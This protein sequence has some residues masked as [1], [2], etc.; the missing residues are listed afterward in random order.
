MNK[1]LLASAIASAL[2]VGVGAQAA[3][4]KTSG[5]VSRAIVAP[6][7]AE[8]DELQFVDNSI[9]G[10]RFRFT[11]DQDIGNG[12]KA[13]FRLEMQLQ[14]NRGSQST[15][16][17]FKAVSDG[18]DFRYQDIY[19]SGSFGKISLGKGDGAA[20]G[21]T[22]HDLSG[23]YTIAAANATDLYGSYVIDD[24]TTTVNNVYGNVDAYSRV[25]RLR[26]DSNNFN[27][28][29]FAASYG[30]QEVA[31]LAVKFEGGSDI[32]YVVQGYVGSKGKSL[33]TENDGD[34][35]RGFSGSVLL[36][37]GLNVT[38]TWSELDSDSDTDE[39][40]EN[41]WVKVGYKMGKH[42][43]AVDYGQTEDSK[44]SDSAFESDADT[45]GLSYVFAPAKGV[46]LYAGYREYGY[47]QKADGG[48]DPKFYT[49]GSLVKF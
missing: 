48:K 23:T 42:A 49:V 44:D 35:T 8:G 17:T 37:N 13:G 6:D 25:N 12:M 11:G 21:A 31:E 32:Q 33:E 10:S 26:Y 40:R 5:Q 18:S 46:E 34:K 1:K 7:D 15:G 47:D 20:N 36:A 4:F 39:D 41:M 2:V 30:Q 19:F 29:S 9:S 24:T 14:S 3:D 43:F 28:L 38:A 22:E 45:T 16:D 27:G